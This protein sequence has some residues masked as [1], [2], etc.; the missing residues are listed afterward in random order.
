[1]NKRM[2]FQH[3]K[4]ND[5]F[6]LVWRELYGK[7][8]LDYPGGDTDTSTYMARFPTEHFTIVCLQICGLGAESE[9]HEVLDV[10]HSAGKL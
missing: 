9:A 7:P 6:R 8:M 2:H 10:L 3:H 1:M 4:D 5:A